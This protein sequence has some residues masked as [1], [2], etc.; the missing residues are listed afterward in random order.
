[1]QFSVTFV[2]YK[3][4]CKILTCRK[5][6]WNIVPNL[7]II[8]SDMSNVKLSTNL[9][10]EIYKKKKILTEVKSYQESNSFPVSFAT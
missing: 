9:S 7:A 3:P 6:Q 5:D 8:T 1:M 10:I 4:Y 2:K